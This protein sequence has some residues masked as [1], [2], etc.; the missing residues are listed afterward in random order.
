[1]NNNPMGMLLNVMQSGG[2][3]R[4]LMQQL[5]TQDPRARMAMQMM[6]GKSGKEIE[7]IVRNMARERGIDINALAGEYG[8]Q[9]PN[10]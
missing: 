7:Q 6:K 3:P 4:A 8:I 10:K 5:A 2:D 9:I 1:M